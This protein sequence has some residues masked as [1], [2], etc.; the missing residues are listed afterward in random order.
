[1]ISR[2]RQEQSQIP[3]EFRQFLVESRPPLDL[4]FL[5]IK[6]PGV[7]VKSPFRF[8]L[9]FL[10]KLFAGDS[11]LPPDPIPAILLQDRAPSAQYL[12]KKQAILLIYSA[13]NG[14]N[15]PL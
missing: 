15:S 3:Q 11:T 9:R 2:W 10:C 8:F 5:F 12:S 13:S 4:Q 6:H 14:P 7:I 1:M